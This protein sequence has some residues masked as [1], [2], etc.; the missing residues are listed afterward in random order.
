MLLNVD[1]RYG[2]NPLKGRE[3]DSPRRAAQQARRAQAY[4]RGK[5]KIL[6]LFARMNPGKVELDAR[7]QVIWKDEM[8]GEF[9][10]MATRI[11]KT[12][13]QEVGDV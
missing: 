2:A 6:T 8:H 13:G 5:L 7:G 9:V 10:V 3:P 12:T 11:D 1:C 4:K